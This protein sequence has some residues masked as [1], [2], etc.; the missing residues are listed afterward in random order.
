MAKPTQG[1][2]FRK[3]RDQIMGVVPA[4]DPGLGKTKKNKPLNATRDVKSKNKSLKEKRVR[5]AST[6]SAVRARFIRQD[7]KFD[8]NVP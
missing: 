6:I 5:S 3:F 2:L 7:Y 4:Q 8:I 1:A